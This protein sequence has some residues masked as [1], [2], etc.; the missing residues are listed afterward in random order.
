MRILQVNTVD[1]GGGAG[2]VVWELFRSY[3]SL[4]HS[5][6]LAVGWKRSEDPN[7][8]IIASD[9][10]RNPWAKLCYLVRGLKPLKVKIWGFRPMQGLLGL[11][12]EPIRFSKR[13]YGIE[14]FHY[15]GSWRVIADSPVQ[16][17]IVH[18]HN[19]HGGYFDLRT[20]P[21]LSH[22]IPVI[23]TVH[24]AWLL[25]GHC[26][27]SFGCDKWMAGCGHCPDLSIYPAIQRDATDYNWKKKC[28]IYSTCR[29]H[30]ATPS[31]WLM[32]KVE[33]SMLAPAIIDSKVIP[34]GVDLTVFRPAGQQTAR[35]KL[36]ISQNSK[37]LLFT[38]NS[39]RDNIFKDYQTLRDV[40]SRISGQP[41][42][43]EILFIALGEDAPS[44]RIGCAEI[45]FV[46][47]K[48]DASTVALY[49]QAA[50]IY[51]HAAKVDTFPTSVLE[52]LACGK[53]VVATGVG[54]IPEQVKSLGLQTSG[55]FSPTYGADMATGVLVTQG[56]AETMEKAIVSLLVDSNLRKRLGENAAQDA[57]QHFSLDQQVRA[58]LEWYK[59]IIE[60]RGTECTGLRSK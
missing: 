46:P 12:A 18:C 19:L 9:K 53:P 56:N 48:T 45:V 26:G 50:D 34:N 29:I 21:W 23:F 6:A 52:A 11:I 39:I 27:H 40:I 49:Y 41:S 51:I 16:P 55:G 33:R 4:G 24:D 47:Y 32:E 58:Y 8:R 22:R 3:R 38:A 25:S 1:I 15:P 14:D 59:E 10:Y 44:E 31:R 13:K 7:V 43:R 35:A 2:N 17:Q 5:C 36:G 28:R 60:K 20:I 54:G 37:V 57:R 42:G 30:V